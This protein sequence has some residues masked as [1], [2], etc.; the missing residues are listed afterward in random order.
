MDSPPFT[1]AGLCGPTTAR[2]PASTYFA[3]F[4][5]TP[6]AMAQDPQSSR[7]TVT[8]I[9]AFLTKGVRLQCWSLA[10]AAC[11]NFTMRGGRM[12]TTAPLFNVEGFLFPSQLRTQWPSDALHLSRT[13]GRHA[14]GLH[15]RRW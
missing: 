14:R 12:K 3:A 2:P 7:H 10:S 11:A 5:P 6:P 8:V 15:H 9:K 13:A 4:I 1:T